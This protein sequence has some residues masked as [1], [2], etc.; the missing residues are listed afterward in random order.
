M[1]LHRLRT[2]PAWSIR[3]SKSEAKGCHQHTDRATV[4]QANEIFFVC[5]SAARRGHD[6]TSASEK[7]RTGTS[8]R[9]LAGTEIQFG[10]SFELEGRPL[11]SSTCCIRP[12]PVTAVTLSAVAMTV[13]KTYAQRE[14]LPIAGFALKQ[15]QV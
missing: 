1:S 15:K 2:A 10:K 6:W 4:Q 14:S 11:F 7:S 9:R 8:V 5:H 3:S 12:E 13:K